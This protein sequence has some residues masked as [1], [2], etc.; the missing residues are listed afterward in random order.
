MNMKTKISEEIVARIWQHQLVTELLTD[1]G[2]RLQVIYPGRVS[3]DKGCDFRDAIFVING[4]I[5][6]G[7]VEIHVRSS[8]WYNHGH[9]RNPDYNK[10]VLHVVM[11]HDRKSP[12]SLQNGNTV[13]TVCLNPFLSISSDKLYHQFDSLQTPLFLCP[14]AMSHSDKAYLAKLLDTVGEERFMLKATSS[15]N[16]LSQNDPGQVLFQGIMRALGYSKNIRPFEELA[17]RLPLSFLEALE[18]GPGITVRQAWMLG[19]AGLLPSQRPGLKS[20]L[21]SGTETDEIEQVWQASGA[22]RT[23]K[24]SDWNFFRV[25][26]DNS[27]TRRLAAMCYLLL[28]YQNQG[29]ARGV[30]SLLYETPVKA[31]HRYLENA[32]IVAGQDCRT[33]LSDFGMVKARNSALL[34]RE[35]A[36]E[37]VINII[38]PLAYAWGNKSAEPKL[39]E[40]AVDIYHRYPG[41]ADNELTRHMKQQLLCR[42]N[43]SFSACQQQGLIHIFNSYC[44]HRNCTRCP[45]ALNRG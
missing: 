13:P 41:L 32:L 3:N 42:Q 26:P 36:D 9:H 35:K 38:L 12:I 44:R 4:K 40:K 8:Q 20:R 16:A 33:G 7:D 34:G 24:E 25:R 27:P 17:C 6:E 21:V 10:I 39:K 2:E 23:L 37:I 19:T 45:V 29:L 22:T 15:L 14:H 5:T 31:E 11:W 1:A 28:R 18:H 30:L 43:L